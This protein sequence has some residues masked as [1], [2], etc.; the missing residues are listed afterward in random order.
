MRAFIV[1]STLVCL[2]AFG[3]AIAQT[4]YTTTETDIGT[5]LD[6]PAAVAVIEKYVPGFSSKD[7]IDMARPMTLKSIQ[8]FAPETYTDKVLADIDAGFAK[9]PSKK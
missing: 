6:D 3:A 1:A 8:Q 5:L 4:H 9:L 7:Q 2:F